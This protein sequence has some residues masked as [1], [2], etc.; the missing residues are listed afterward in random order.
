MLELTGAEVGAELLAFFAEPISSFI[1][2]DVR[3]QYIQFLAAILFIDAV[4]AI[5]F[6]RLRIEEK[7]LRF[8]VIKLIVI[9]LTIILNLLLIVK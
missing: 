9:S 3:P 1:D 5:P 8:A 2:E 7:A 6:A 4:V